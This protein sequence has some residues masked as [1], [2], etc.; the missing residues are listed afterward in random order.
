VTLIVPSTSLLVINNFVL[1][2]PTNHTWLIT[3]GFPGSRDGKE[4]A[5][6]A[7]DLGLITGSGRSHEEGN[8]YHSNILA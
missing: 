7:G 5:C 2:I 4:Y 6:N 8:G 1:Q 3:M